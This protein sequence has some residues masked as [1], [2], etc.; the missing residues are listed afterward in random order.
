M[1]EN[2]KME[3]GENPETSAASREERLTVGAGT[4][5]GEGHSGPLRDESGV[6]KFRHEAIAVVLSVRREEG[7]EPCLCVLTERR[8]R[9]PFEDLP[10]LPSGP[11]EVDESLDQSV[12]RHVSAK[13]GLDELA[14]LEQLETRSDPGRDPYDRTVGTAYLGITPWSVNPEPREGVSWLPVADLPPMAFDHGQLVQ[15]AVERARAK[16][17]YTNIGFAFAAE[18]FTIAELRQTYA[19][20][21]GQDVSATNLQRI[22][23]RRGQLEPTGDVLPSGSGGGRPAKMFRFVARKLTVTDPAAVFKK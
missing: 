9:A 6:A 11:M 5:A 15:E 10:A 1:G 12:R 4:R 22:L 14:H 3:P 7:A 2:K 21:L 17:S 19:A 8:R 23:A 13:T 20:A 18:E 16:L